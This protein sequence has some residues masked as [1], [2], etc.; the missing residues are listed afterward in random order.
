MEQHAVAP[1]AGRSRSVGTGDACLHGTAF[2]YKPVRLILRQAE[3][4]VRCN[5]RSNPLRD[6]TLI[7]DRGMMRQKSSQR[8][9]GEHEAPILA[10]VDHPKLT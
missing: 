8:R 1:R 10:F 9:E 3:N 4:V 7:H 2:G 5:W 6:L